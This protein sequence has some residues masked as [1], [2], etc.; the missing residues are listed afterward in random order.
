MHYVKEIMTYK[1]VMSFMDKFTRKWTLKDMFQ[2]LFCFLYV[3]GHSN[4]NKSTDPYAVFLSAISC[5]FDW[6]MVFFWNLS[7]NLWKSLVF[8]YAKSLYVSLF[9]EFLSLK[10]N[11]VHLYSKWEVLS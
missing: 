10:Y 11:E 9:L 2:I 8:L 3:R 5:K 6:K 1:S 7:S 4:M